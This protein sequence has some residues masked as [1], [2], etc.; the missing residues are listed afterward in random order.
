MGKRPLHSVVLIQQM[1]DEIVGITSYF[2][3]RKATG[4]LDN[5]VAL[6]KQAKHLI[7]P[8]LIKVFHNCL[9]TKT[10]PD[11]LKIAK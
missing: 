8:F 9:K 6:T 1:N 7:A 3:A 2:N 4:Y 5:P 11:V 10:Y